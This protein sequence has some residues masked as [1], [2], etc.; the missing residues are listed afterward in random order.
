MPASGDPVLMVPLEQLNEEIDKRLEGG[1][2][3]L[4][5]GVETFD[6]LTVAEQDFA[7]WDEVNQELLR[8]RFS[9]SEVALNYQ[10]RHIGMGGRGT[11]FQE[12]EMLHS[13]IGGQ[14]RKLNSVKQRLPY[15]AAEESVV[16]APM[17]AAGHGSKI[18]VVHGHDGAVRSEVVEFLESVTGERPV[19][20]H[21]QA[22][23]GRTIIEKFEDHAD[24]AGFAVVLLTGDDLG[25]DDVDSLR[26]R[27][28]QNVVLELGFFIGRLTRKR[29]VALYESGVD[30]PSDLSGVLYKPLAGNWKIELASELKAADIEVDGT[31]LL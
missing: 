26:A 6:A 9:N 28:R 8:R 10:T 19:V 24:D 17:K 25:G 29:V 30:L 13:R 5:R 21:E 23:S 15:M 7:T 20:L 27:P 31:K 18:F 22:D 12:L 3:L 4:G 1:K 16:Q 14:I 2:E 11:V